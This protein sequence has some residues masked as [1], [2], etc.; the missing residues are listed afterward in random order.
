MTAT[1]TT[2]HRLDIK[3]CQYEKGCL[4]GGQELCQPGPVESQTNMV[5]GN[6][7]LHSTLVVQ[8]TLY[9]MDLLWMETVWDRGSGVVYYAETMPVLANFIETLP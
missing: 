7:T 4:D 1:R 5:I 3:H 2:I 9:G 8:N 6:I